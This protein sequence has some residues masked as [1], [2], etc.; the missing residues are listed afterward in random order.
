MGR[1][2]GRGIASARASQRAVRWA[3]GA[4]RLLASGDFDYAQADIDELVT[5]RGGKG[6]APL[7]LDL[8]SA[9]VRGTIPMH[10]PFL[11]ELTIPL[12]TPPGVDPGDATYAEL[13]DA[14]LYPTRLRGFSVP[15]FSIDRRRPEIPLRAGKI[16]RA[17]CGS[18]HVESIEVVAEHVVTVWG[19]PGEPSEHR[20]VF[21][22]APTGLAVREARIPPFT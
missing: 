17:S 21:S 1:W 22:K 7:S 10:A 2:S 13:L 8:F 19:H 16:V 11:M 3:T 4:C 5:V 9:M 18:F 15:G 6:L 14:I 20:L 12:P